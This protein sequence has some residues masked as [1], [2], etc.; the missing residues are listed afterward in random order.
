[1]FVNTLMFKYNKTDNECFYWHE[2]NCT[3]LIPLELD[4]GTNLPS[5][6]IYDIHKR[7]STLEQE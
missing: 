7:N 2:C 4:K 3:F 6:I 5:Y 1:M